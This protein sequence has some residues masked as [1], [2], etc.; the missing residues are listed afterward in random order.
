MPESDSDPRTF[1]HREDGVF[2]DD[3]GEPFRTGWYVMLGSQI[4]GPFSSEG[5]ANEVRALAC[6]TGRFA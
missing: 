1:H 3:E 6:A 2:L 5:V 4:R